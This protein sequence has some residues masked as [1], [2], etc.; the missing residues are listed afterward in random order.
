MEILIYTVGAAHKSMFS[1]EQSIFLSPWLRSYIQKKWRQF[2]AAY[3][4]DKFLWDKKTLQPCPP[5]R[6]NLGQQHPHHLRTYNLGWQTLG[7]PCYQPPIKPCRSTGPITYALQQ[8]KRPTFSWTSSRDAPLCNQQADH[9]YP[10]IVRWRSPFHMDPHKWP[11]H[12]QTR[13]WLQPLV[14]QIH[15]DACQQW[16]GTLHALVDELRKQYALDIYKSIALPIYG[17]PPSMTTWT[18][19][20]IP[21]TI[22]ASVYI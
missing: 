18:W 4:K 8:L 9:K 16:P 17:T 6:S 12:Q 15:G 19:P 1:V 14:C 22:I 7:R 10:F 21:S 5:T 13:G 2:N 20:H 11:L 3:D